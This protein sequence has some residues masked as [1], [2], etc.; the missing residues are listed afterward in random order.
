MN[1]YKKRYSTRKKIAQSTALG[2]V[3]FS[4]RTSNVETIDYPNGQFIQ[5]TF[6]TEDGDRYYVEMTEAEL[7]KINSAFRSNPVAHPQ[8]K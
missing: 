5:L 4:H 7:E 2:G 6:E 1:L 8:S 3:S